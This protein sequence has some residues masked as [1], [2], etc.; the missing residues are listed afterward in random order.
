MLLSKWCLLCFFACLVVV[1]VEIPLFFEE[2]GVF[3]RSLLALLWMWVYT[4]CCFFVLC[5]GY[6]VKRGYLKAMIEKERKRSRPKPIW[7]KPDFGHANDVA[8]SIVYTLLFFA[9]AYLPVGFEN[10]T[11]LL[12]RFGL[13]LPA[14]F[15]TWFCVRLVAYAAHQKGRYF[16]RS[17]WRRPFWPWLLGAWFP[18]YW[19]GYFPINPALFLSA[20]VASYFEQEVFIEFGLGALS[21]WVF[22]FLV[23][24]VVFEAVR[25][26]FQEKYAA[27]RAATFVVI[28]L[29]CAH[30][31]MSGF[32]V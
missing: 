6:C 27:R 22:W 14:A 29:A 1:F 11:S 5:I 23:L 20:E 28:G 31:L 21:V 8:N 10:M 30:A 3:F 7:H 25:I 2:L 16:A 32:G 4:L 17:L 24:A 9:V 18:A 26:R 19:A 12:W 15:G 13:A